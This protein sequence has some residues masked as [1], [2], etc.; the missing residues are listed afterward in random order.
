MRELG[1]LRE[2]QTPHLNDFGI[3][4][5]APEP[6]NHLF[7]SLETPG[8][9]KKSKTSRL[10]LTKSYFGENHF[11]ELKRLEMLEKTGAENSDDP[12]DKFSRILGMGSISSRKHEMGM[13]FN[14]FNFN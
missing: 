14:K 10:C 2:P 13:L 11:G 12:S 5:R 1:E 6:Q 7:L 8:L 3:F 4:E 9:F